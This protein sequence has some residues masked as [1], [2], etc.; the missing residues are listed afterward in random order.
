M[1]PRGNFC[2]PKLRSGQLATF[3]RIVAD[4]RDLGAAA[5]AGQDELAACTAQLSRLLHRQEQLQ[6]QPQQKL[7]PPPPPPHAAFGSLPTAVVELTLHY[8]DT[9]TLGR[10]ACAARVFGGGRLSLVERVARSAACRA[11]CCTPPLLPCELLS[12]AAQLRRHE[13]PLAL[14]PIV[15]I[16][17]ARRLSAD[18]GRLDEAARCFRRALAGLEADQRLVDQHASVE[19]ERCFVNGLSDA[20]NGLATVRSRQI[21]G[22]TEARLLFGRVLAS[23]PGDLDA[24]CNLAQLDVRSG[25]YKDAE[26]LCRRAMALAPHDVDVLDTYG[27][28]LSKD[29]ARLSEAEAVLRRALVAAPG[30]SYA[31]GTL[32]VVMSARSGRGSA[33]AAE[34]QTL[35]GEAVVAAATED[36]ASKAN[37]LAARGIV[38]LRAGDTEGARLLL[39][40]S[41]ERGG[42]AAAFTEDLA[43]LLQCETLWKPPHAV[44]MLLEQH[45]APAAI[46]AWWGK[47]GLSTST[48]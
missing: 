18:P 31:L 7:L 22:A 33:A 29:M 43:R 15:L 5:P 12:R 24:L 28:V 10:V 32:A 6:Q 44:R 47:L 41:R 2:E 23:E 20:L 25:S 4:L 21:G 46:K 8:C 19:G 40:E 39:A 16:D 14:D 13:Q 17:F 42:A 37:A 1:R 34:A 36:Q 11:R 3:R 45:A 35:S 38:R 30:F 26:A 9:P 27:Y 48:A